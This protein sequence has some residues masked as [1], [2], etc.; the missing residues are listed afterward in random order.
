VLSHAYDLRIHDETQRTHQYW[1]VG[2]AVSW[3]AGS[4]PAMTE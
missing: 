4:S 3:I 2:G 1:H